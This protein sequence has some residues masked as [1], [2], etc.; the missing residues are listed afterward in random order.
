M[1]DCNVS[2]ECIRRDQ[3]VDRKPEF[4]MVSKIGFVD[5]LV[6]NRKQPRTLPI[7]RND[8]CNAGA[9]MSPK[10]ILHRLVRGA[11]I[12]H[13]LSRL[14]V[15]PRIMQGFRRKWGKLLKDSTR[16]VNRRPAVNLIKANP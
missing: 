13:V 11:R 6:A 2:A 9:S 16:M 1:T 8:V 4:R 10:K 15:R 14:T 3:S 5:T 12:E 7:R